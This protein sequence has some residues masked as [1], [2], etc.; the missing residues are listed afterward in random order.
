MQAQN[1]ITMTA[2]MLVKFVGILIV[3]PIFI[4][5]GSIITLL[6]AL[7]GQIYMR[8]QLPVKREMSKARAPVLGHFNAAVS[9]ISE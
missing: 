8:A 2:I 5:P 7:C 1:L 6:G 3:S 4:I 9:G